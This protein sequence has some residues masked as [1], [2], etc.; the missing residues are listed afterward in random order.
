MAFFVSALGLQSFGD[1]W[2]L[3]AQPGAWRKF[4]LCIGKGEPGFGYIGYFQKIPYVGSQEG[5]RPFWL[6]FGA[7]GSF[8]A[9]VLTICFLVLLAASPTTLI[10]G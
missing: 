2:S 9:A 5:Q 1:P 4:F 8:E 3:V 6:P 7:G 10:G